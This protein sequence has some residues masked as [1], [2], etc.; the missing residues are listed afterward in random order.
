MLSKIM[1]DSQF[2]DQDQLQLLQLLTRRAMSERQRRIEVKETFEF[3]DEP[4]LIANQP[5]DQIPSQWHLV[6]E[7]TSLYHW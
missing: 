6:S 1:A 4:P 2:T 7:S 3:D 5:D